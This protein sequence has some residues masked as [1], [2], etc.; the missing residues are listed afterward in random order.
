[1]ISSQQY[2]TVVGAFRRYLGKSTIVVA[3]SGCSMVEIPFLSSNHEVVDISMLSEAQ[4]KHYELSL[5]YI[6]S[7]HYD[8]AETKLLSLVNE[9]PGFPDAYNALG[10]VYERRGRVTEGGE[11]FYKAIELNPNYSVAVNN[12]S[13][14]KCYV[15]G[16]DEILQKAVA[17]RD[18]RV[19][20][21][22]YTA[23]TKCYINQS[24]FLKGREA[25]D[26]A[27]ML[28]NNYALSYF[29]LAKIQ[30]H[31][32]QYNEA[33]QS[34]NR[35]NDLNGYTKASALLGLSINRFLDDQQEMSKYH[36]VLKTQFNGEI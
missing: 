17:A 35:F 31:E 10:V 20:S 25:I 32:K 8:V 24:Q 34:I 30:H 3:L 28:D 33:K 36:N 21:R 23:A 6:D 29:Y 19:K 1:M 14:L 11:A 7:A 12:Y 13:D 22:L 27:L 9:Y 26:Q 15:A 4:Q 2:S 18:Q 5:H 16:G